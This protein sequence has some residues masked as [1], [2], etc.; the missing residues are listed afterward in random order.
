MTKPKVVILGSFVVDLTGRAPHLPVP[1]ETVKGS[2]FKMGPGGKGSN[3]GVAAQRAGAEVCMI[4]KV[5]RDPFGR[6]ALDNFINE[7]MDT[8]LVF[9]DE[10]YE[11][12]AA[13]IM[14]D[15]NSGQNKILVSLGACNNITPENMEAAGRGMERADFFLTQLETN[16]EAIEQGI[17]M[18]YKKGMKIILNPAPVQPVSDELLKKLDFI[19]PNEIEASVLTGIDIKTKDDIRAAAEVFQNKGVKNVIITMGSEGSYA[20]TRDEELFIPVIP[21]DPVETTGAGDAFNGGFVTALAEGMDFFKAAYIGNIA[22]CLSVTRLGTAP[23]MPY[24]EE[25]DRYIKGFDSLSPVRVF[26]EGLP[27]PLMS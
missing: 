4:T 9:E 2:S 14:V 7:K 22:G 15:E 5:G 18:A 26:S 23:A 10:Y 12:G 27:V 8:S 19:T 3:Q 11:T 16:M 25:I 17:D 21:V 20:R 13:L 24:R 6:I 1:G